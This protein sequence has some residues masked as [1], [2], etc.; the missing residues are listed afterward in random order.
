MDSY[1]TSFVYPRRSRHTLS[2]TSSRDYPHDNYPHQPSPL[3]DTLASDADAV[4]NL[5]LSAM[6]L[7]NSHVSY[8]I[9]DHG[10]AFNFH[11]TG[12]YQQVMLARGLILKDCP[13]QVCRVLPITVLS[14]N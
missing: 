2:P 12:T 6:Q 11:I 14:Y 10:K 8:F 7:H 5:A 4:Q 3:P 13:I 9:V 1:S